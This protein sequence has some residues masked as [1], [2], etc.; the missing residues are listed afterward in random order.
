MVV[1]PGEYRETLTLKS[2]IRVVSRVPRGAVIRLPGSASD[3][4]AAIVAR[5]VTDAALE[6][7][8]SIGDA[9]TP[10]GTGIAVTNSELSMSGVEIT[11]AATAAVE[12][13]AT[14]R[15][16]LVGSDIHDNPGAA[17][18]VRP[19]ANA[20]ISHNVFMRNGSANAPDRVD[21]RGEQRSDI[22]GQ[23]LPR[24]QPGH[25]RADRAMRAPRWPATTGSWTAARRAAAS[26]HGP[27]AVEVTMTTVFHR[28]GAYEILHQVGSGGMAAVFLATDTRTNRQV[29]LKLVSIE[30]D[31]DGRADHRGRAPGN[32][33]AGSILPRQPVRARRS[34]STAPRASTSSSRW[35]TWTA[36]ISPT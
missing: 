33:A 32:E 6:G 15:V 25:V 21:R 31:N 34:T 10:L 28:V 5:D 19:G 8:A 24:D 20:T 22:H 2:Y 35:S 26:V 1:E 13:D 4:D 14:S 7:S 12:V 16:R 11:G 27:V 36:R 3:V 9:A 23:R 29:A 18:V 30:D 17:L